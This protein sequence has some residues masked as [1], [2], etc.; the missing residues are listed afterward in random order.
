MQKRSANS[1]LVRRKRRFVGGD[2][3]GLV[4]AGFSLWL[5]GVL[6]GEGEHAH[7]VP[8]LL[9]RGSLAQLDRS[10]NE[11]PGAVDIFPSCGHV[12]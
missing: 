4:R 2:L 3:A 12:L 10:V 6:D 7:H 9:A 5:A 1:S 8:A 11:T